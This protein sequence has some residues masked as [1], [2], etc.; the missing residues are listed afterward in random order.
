MFVWYLLGKNTPGLLCVYVHFHFPEVLSP[1]APCFCVFID[2]LVLK[3]TIN[4][5]VFP[6]EIKSL[7]RSLSFFI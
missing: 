1:E 5:S 3:S 4:L 6:L 2:I 7:D